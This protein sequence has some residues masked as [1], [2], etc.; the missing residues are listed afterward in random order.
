MET[1]T[2][3]FGPIKLSNYRNGLYFKQNKI[4]FKGVTLCQEVQCKLLV[5]GKV[6]TLN[7]GETVKTR[8]CETC[9]CKKFGQV[10]VMCTVFSLD[11]VSPFPLF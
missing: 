3:K 2:T 11:T 9:T 10:C 8:K 7:F 4:G 5:D 6:K 1:K